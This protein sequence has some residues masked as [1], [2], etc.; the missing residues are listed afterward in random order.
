MGVPVFGR[1][2]I[3]GKGTLPSCFTLAQ[4]L[5]RYTAQLFLQDT[6]ANVV[7]LYGHEV[8]GAVT[9]RFPPLEIKKKAAFIW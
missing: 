7:V 8:I 3:S 2:E 9:H 4:S 1:R 5:L 6:W